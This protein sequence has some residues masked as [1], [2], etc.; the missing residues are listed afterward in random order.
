MSKYYIIAGEASGDLHG[1]NLISEIKKLD[2]N[3]VFRGIGGNM[4]EQQGVSLNEHYKNTAFMGFKEVILNLHKISKILKKCKSDILKF[5][6]D[7]VILIDY[8][9]FNFRIADFAKKNDFKVVYYI[10]PQIWAWK[11]NRI[12]KI[13]KNIDTLISILPFEQEFY[14]KHNYKVEYAGHP[15]VENINKFQADKNFLINNKLNDKELIAILPGSRKQEIQKILEVLISVKN[16]FKDYNFV[17]AGSSNFSESFYRDIIK[18]EN[19]A[20]IFEKTYDILFHAKVALITSGTA[21]LEAA[22]FELPLV[23]CYKTTSLNYQ[24]FKRLAKV[25]YISLVNLILDKEAVKE[26]IQSNLNKLNLKDELDLLLNDEKRINQL[27]QNYQDLRILLGNAN[28]SKN[29]AE[30]INKTIL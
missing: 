28:A 17:I 6:P 15:L 11:E 29:A 16:D 7:V 27:K 1:S 21:V 23:V 14:K 12:K 25:K 18:D 9:G 4:M 22:L 20:I 10:S 24:I 19:I 2:K 26:L 3:A 5:N 8:P 30:I 13:K